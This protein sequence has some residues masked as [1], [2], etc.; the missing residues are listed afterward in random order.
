MLVPTD[1][2]PCLAPLTRT[3]RETRTQSE[4][5]P[6]QKGVADQAPPRYSERQLMGK[7]PQG[8]GNLEI[9]DGFGQIEADVPVPG[10]RRGA[11]PLV[12]IC[13][14]NTESQALA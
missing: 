11:S 13:L 14:A 1:P 2:Q 10:P 5:G 8:P 7:S 4:R 12:F 6:K 3:P 9:L